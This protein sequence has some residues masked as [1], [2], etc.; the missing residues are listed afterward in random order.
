MIVWDRL[1]GTFEPERERVRYGL[2]HD[3]QTFNPL[4]IAVHEWQALARDLRR[5]RTVRQA[6]GYV[7]AAPGWGPHGT[8]QT[9][10]DLRRVQALQ[11]GPENAANKP[12]NQKRSS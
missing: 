2:T 6:F 9:A 12:E 3:I 5:A 10:N 8:S 11:N 7:F 1:F 4:R